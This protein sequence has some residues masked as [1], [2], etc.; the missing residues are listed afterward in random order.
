M[1][2]C[3][4]YDNGK[5]VCHGDCTIES[6]PAWGVLLIL[7]RDAQTGYRLITNADYYVWEA[8]GGYK[9]H[10]WESNFV[11]LIDYLARPGWKKVLIGRLVE[12]ET[13]DAVFREAYAMRDQLIR[14]TT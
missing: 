13:Y 2:W 7:D 14:G 8:R 12:N 4:Y 9:A 3:V 6:L 11:G 5:T 1:E 10:W